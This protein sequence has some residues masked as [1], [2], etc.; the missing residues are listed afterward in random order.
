MRRSR[1]TSSGA[2]LFE[3]KGETK[4]I[5]LLLRLWAIKKLFDVVRGSKRQPAPAPTRR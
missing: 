2:F 1:E 4:M 5:G 3:P